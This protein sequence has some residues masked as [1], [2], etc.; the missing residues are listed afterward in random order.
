[1]PGGF[2]GLL[3]GVTWAE[4]FGGAVSEILGGG[5]GG[6]KAEDLIE[7]AGLGASACLR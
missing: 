7:A 1:M 3:E 2:A 4:S 6:G 5:G